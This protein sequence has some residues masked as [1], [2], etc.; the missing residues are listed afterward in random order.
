MCLCVY[1]YSI[2]CENQEW[3]VRSFRLW[4]WGYFGKIK[5]C[6]PVLDLVLGLSMSRV[7]VVGVFKPGVFFLERGMLR[8]WL[9]DLCFHE[10]VFSS[11]FRDTAELQMWPPSLTFHLFETWIT[12]WLLSSYLYQVLPKTNHTHTVIQSRYI[13]REEKTMRFGVCL[14]QEQWYS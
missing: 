8:Q 12:H 9:T 4:Q 7:C 6:V 13:W 11:I 3:W 2:H 14:L 5:T 10:S 1:L